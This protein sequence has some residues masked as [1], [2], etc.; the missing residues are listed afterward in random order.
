MSEA[1]QL[2]AGETTRTRG[3]IEVPD[4]V[5]DL[6]LRIPDGSDTAEAYFNFGL[7]TDSFADCVTIHYPWRGVVSNNDAAPGRVIAVRRNY[8]IRVGVFDTLTD[9]LAATARTVTL[10]DYTPGPEDRPHENALDFFEHCVS[11]GVACPRYQAEATKRERE[12]IREALTRER[13]ASARE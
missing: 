1:S 7:V 10:P 9:A 13:E 2:D 4:Y 8:S 6:S 11:L 3:F 5:T 12:A